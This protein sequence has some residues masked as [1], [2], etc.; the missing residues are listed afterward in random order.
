MPL[1]EVSVMDQ[2][3]E[4]ILHWK[5]KLTTFA[6]LCRDFGIAR[7]TGYK[8]LKRYEE[9]GMSGLDPLSTAPHNRPNKTPEEIEKRIIEFRGEKE[10][11]GAKKIHWK[12]EQENIYSYIP[13]ISTIGNILKRNGLIPER[14]KR[15]RVEPRKPIFDPDECNQIWSADFKGKFKMGNGKYCHPLTI[16]D[17]YSR[18]ILAVQ[19]MENPNTE[20]S[21]PVFERVFKEYG[22]HYNFTQTTVHLLQI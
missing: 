12:L 3:L 2:K 20:N 13:S 17:S 11:W 7:S 19:G 9:N 22:L 14:K 21:K 4:F 1:M 10:R 15:K 5:S 6:Q 8:Y 18:Y 16:C